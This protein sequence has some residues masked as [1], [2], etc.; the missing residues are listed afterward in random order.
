MRTLA[1]DYTHDDKVYDSQ[2]ENQFFTGEAI[3][4]A[5]F[6][7]TTDFGKVYFPE[8]KWYNLYTG[9]VESGRQEKIVAAGLQ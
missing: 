2:F 1:I 8:G 5:P 9:E 4:V 7:S 6:E 3:M